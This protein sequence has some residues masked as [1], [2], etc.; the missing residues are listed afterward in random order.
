[1]AVAVVVENIK[2]TVREG[3]IISEQIELSGLFPIMVS[4]MVSVGEASGTLEGMLLK[5]ADFY[6][7]EVEI[8]IKALTSVIEPIMIVAMGL[9]IGVIVLS[10]ML[11]MFDMMKLAK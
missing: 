9:I 4:K 11:P 1:M 5:V 8:E 7:D 6:D 2:N 10:V 3:G